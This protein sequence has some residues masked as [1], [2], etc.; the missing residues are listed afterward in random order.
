MRRHAAWLGLAAH[1]E[2][3]VLRDGWTFAFGWMTPTAA[4]P[5]AYFHETGQYLYLTTGAGLGDARQ[6]DGPEHQW[7]RRLACVDTNT[8]YLRLA[9]DSRRMTVVVPVATP[10]QFYFARDGQGCAFTNDLRLLIHW[11]GLDLDERAVYALFQ[12]GRIPPPL[13]ICASMSRVPGGH[14]LEIAPDPFEPVFQRHF[15][16]PSRASEKHDPAVA[17]AAVQETLDSVL[18]SVPAPAA[19]YFSG[20]VDSGLVAARLAK[21]G[22]TDVTLV[23]YSFGP[24]DDRSSLAMQIAS[25][26]G[27]PYERVTYD[28]AG[29]AHVLARLGKDYSYPF[30]GRS[31]I[32]TNLMVH[33]STGG[34]G[35]PAAII[36][37][38]G[39]DGAFGLGPRRRIWERVYRI[40]TALRRLV[41]ACH[42]RLGG[43]KYD[44]TF[45]KLQ[46]IGDVALGS[47]QM[48]LQHLAVMS[49][50]C[51]DGI[52]YTIPPVV[53]RELRGTIRTYTE[54]LGSD[55][56][57][58]DAFCLLDIVSVCAGEFA[59]KC[60]D[61]LRRK[62]VT[63]VFP[64]LE[65]PMIRTA[66]SLGWNEKC[67]KGEPK[68]LLK[69]ML[70]RAIPREWVYLP[71]GY[72]IPP[73]RRW[74]RHPS[75]REFL[76]D[77][78]LSPANPLL[79]FCDDRVI[80]RMIDRAE[81]GLGYD[82]GTQKFL[83]TLMFTSGWLSQLK[84]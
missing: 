32:P 31:A 68:G 77:V 44:S 60:F 52:A 63:A 47:V 54:V 6:A 18:A 67:P 19:L 40:P 7:E 34:R 64:F 62:G 82:T 3:R 2:T 24:D 12:N 23:N 65:P 83:W 50:N 78:V 21:L 56:D 39:A 45:L 53:R 58:V 37:G 35:S 80:C 38:T 79:A 72:F 22:R 55:L 59:A 46:R 33:E 70:G 69:Q 75:N 30:G 43:W 8:I 66:F 16:L 13:T 61:P 26:L 11:R 27:M 28:P 71:K 20:G 73:F 81:R 41:G 25:H 29:L 42:Q 1:I 51:L 76:H 57:S 84:F 15:H 36:E 49:Q 74:L 9:L 48:P 5:T 17:E 14:T 10:E 4:D